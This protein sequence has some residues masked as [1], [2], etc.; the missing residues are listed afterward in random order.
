MLGAFLGR[1]ALSVTSINKAATAARDASRS[2]KESQDV[3]LA[4]ENLDQLAQQ[5][6]DLQKQF[7]ADVAAQQAKVDPATEK[8]DTITIRPRKSIISVQLVALAWQP[9]AG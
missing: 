8:L 7:A 4:S 9:D 1:K 2:W 5:S 3:G 6:A